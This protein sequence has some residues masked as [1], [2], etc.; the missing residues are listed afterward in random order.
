MGESW[1]R[2]MQTFL[3][4]ADHETLQLLS[5]VAW[6]VEIIAPACLI[7]P[8]GAIVLEKAIKDTYGLQTSFLQKQEAKQGIQ[9]FVA[10]SQ[11]VSDG[12][13]AE[14]KKKMGLLVKAASSGKIEESTQVSRYDFT[15]GVAMGEQGT[16]SQGS[17]G[18]T[19]VDVQRKKRSIG[20]PDD[21]D[22]KKKQKKKTDK[23][24]ADS[25]V[26]KPAATEDKAE[27]EDE[28]EAD[29]EAKKSPGCEDD[30]A[31]DAAAAAHEGRED[32]ESHA[33]A[34]E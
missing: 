13:P 19:A 24:A 22:A 2:A 15:K 14:Q 29:A 17:A 30:E 7:I 31:A 9:N 26:D 12:L 10:L 4:D 27:D 18:D 1:W 16:G 5:K 11:L 34:A 28:P 25:A 23:K 20:A 32:N 3:Q 8:P 33:D 6:S 21:D